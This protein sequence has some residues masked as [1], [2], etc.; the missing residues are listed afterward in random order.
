MLPTPTR[1]PPPSSKETSLTTNASYTTSDISLIY[2]PN[3][4]NCVFCME[5]FY[6]DHKQSMELS[7]G[8][9]HRVTGG[10]K[11]IILHS[12]GCK[13][14]SYLWLMDTTN[15]IEYDTISAISLYYTSLKD[16][17]F[18]NRGDDEFNYTLSYLVSLPQFQVVLI[19]INLLCTI[20]HQL[21][22]QMSLR[23]LYQIM[24]HFIIIHEEI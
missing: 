18:I 7:I 13:I 4:Y 20:T 23:H 6:G 21:Q 24:D 1:T 14:Y 3:Y 16:T 8:T 22:H 9:F 12:S 15:M 17:S 19:H 5:P 10:I 2:I 11:C